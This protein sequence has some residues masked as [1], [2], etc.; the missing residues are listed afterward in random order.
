MGC[1]MENFIPLIENIAHRLD[2]L[3]CDPRILKRAQLSRPLELEVFVPHTLKKRVCLDH[4]F[5][6][7]IKHLDLR[8]KLCTDFFMSDS[9]PQ[10]PAL[11]SVVIRGELENLRAIG[12]K[13]AQFRRFAPNLHRLKVRLTCDVDLSTKGLEISAE[14]VHLYERLRSFADPTLR[15]DGLEHLGVEF[16]A[17]CSVAKNA[18]YDTEWT[19]ALREH[20]LFA[21]NDEISFL[22]IPPTKTAE[23]LGVR[24]AT[25]RL[26]LEF[27]A[28]LR[29]SPTYERA[30]A[31][32]RN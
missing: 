21:H 4:I 5:A 9:C 15:I 29:R 6:H 27:R 25:R 14:M 2:Y 3:E 28:E 7:S 11:Q 23:F 19:R 24:W 22:E 18:D 30:E 1:T 31:R 10:Q 32:G 8:A 20:P 26:D 13:F 12:D 17:F 16:A